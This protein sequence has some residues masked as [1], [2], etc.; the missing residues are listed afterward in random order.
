MNIWGGW[1]I[2]AESVAGVGSPAFLLDPVIS[3]FSE[4]KSQNIIPLVLIPLRLARTRAGRR[5][6]TD[7]GSQHFAFG[8]A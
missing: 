5:E 7:A 1:C 4:Q 8:G 2:S 6:E 3:C